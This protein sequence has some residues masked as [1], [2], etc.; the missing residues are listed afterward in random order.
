MNIEEFKN[1]YLGK[2]VEFH[3]YGSGAYNQCVDLVNQYINDVLDNNTKDYT[4]II[5]TNAKDF[6]TNYDKEDFIWISNT[7]YGVPQKGDI[8][9][10]N[11]NVGGGA[12]H[13]AVFLS[14]DVNSFTSLDQNWSQRERVTLETH[15]YNNVSGWLRPVRPINPPED[16]AGCEDDIKKLQ[17]EVRYQENEKIRYKQERNECRNSR[18]KDQLD[19][20]KTIAEKNQTI[21]QYQKQ[22][23]EMSLELSNARK[24]IEELKRE[25]KALEDSLEAHKVKHTKELLDKN[26]TIS[27]LEEGLLASEAQNAS[28]KAENKQL[29]E[30]LKKLSSKRLHEFSWW[31]RF[32]SLWGGEA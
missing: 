8:I 27:R 18:E 3:S 29:K 17:E 24:D 32:K 6:A 12:G 13:V 26:Q 15:N 21:E 19:Y 11:G 10:W 4:E 5:G 16:D 20:S 7:P 28:F 31:K 23:S 1:K 25:K 2:Q 9:V 14:G 22:T 30:D